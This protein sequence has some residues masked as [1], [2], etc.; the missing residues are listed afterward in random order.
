[1]PRSS[2][3]SG[4]PVAIDL[5]FRGAV[6]DVLVR[7]A[8]KLGYEAMA[9]LGIDSAREV[10]R[11]KLIPR[12]EVTRGAIGRYRG[13]RGLRVLLVR[14]ED[15]LK[16]YPKLVGSVDSLR[17]LFE[18]LSGAGKDFWRRVVSF[19]VP[20]ELEFSELLRRILNGNPID[21]H[22]LLLRLYARG[23]VKV[24][25]CSGA[26]DASTL[27]HPTA[28]FS[29]ATLLGVPEVLALKA[30]FK[31]PRELASNAA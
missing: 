8:P 13:S 18:D 3:I 25:M 20:V 4:D 10:G 1:M 28:M 7:Y 15:D 19:G 5:C 16:A 2:R 14:S 6:D 27:V 12:F 26:T 22:Y 29:L 21:Y 17:V 30:V 24:Y 31:T 23:R 11:L 9:V